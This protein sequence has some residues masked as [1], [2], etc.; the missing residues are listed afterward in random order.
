RSTPRGRLAEILVLDQFSRHIH[1]GTPDAF[2]ADGMALALAQEAVAGGHDLTLTV[3][4][5]KFLYLPFEHSESLSVHVQ[6]MA[7]FTALGDADALDWER[8]HLAVLERFGRYPHRNE[9]LGRVSTPEE[10]VYLE[11]PGAGF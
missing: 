7:L 2:A 10:Q 4:E 5:R 6:A 9:V 3:T 8:R 11:E 1:R